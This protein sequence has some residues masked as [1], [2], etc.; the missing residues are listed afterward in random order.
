MCFSNKTDENK[1]VAKFEAAMAAVSGCAAV[2]INFEY[3]HSEQLRP[4]IGQDIV[5]TTLFFF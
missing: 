4:T 2:A 3:G 5:Q 1:N